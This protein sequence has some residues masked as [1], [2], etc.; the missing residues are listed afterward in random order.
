MVP[1]NGRWVRLCF[2]R[3][4][5]SRLEISAEMRA[6]GAQRERAQGMPMMAVW[7]V[8]AVT[9]VMKMVENMQAAKRKW[10]KSQARR[11]VR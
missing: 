3:A 11:R 9:E 5:E 7:M 4:S 1:L 8:A 6:K 2:R 10:E